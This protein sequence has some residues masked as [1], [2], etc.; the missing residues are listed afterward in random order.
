MDKDIF[1]LPVKRWDS[2]ISRLLVLFFSVWVISCGGGQEGAPIILSPAADSAKDITAFSFT[3]AT[4]TALSQD[5]TGSIA[6]TNIYAIVPDG[7]SRAGLV[8]TFSTTGQS[9]HVGGAV[10]TSGSTAND[11]TGTVTYRVTA[12]DTSTKDYLVTV[13]EAPAASGAIIADHLA[14]VAFDTIPEAA[15][16][17][18]KTRLHIAYGHTSHGSQ[19]ISGMTALA[20]LDS[21]YDWR[22]TPTA[23]A[24]H[25]DDYAMDG[26]AGYFP[27]WVNN[28][29]TYLGNPDPATGR[30]TTRPTINVVIWSWCGQVNDRTEQTMISTYLAPMTELEA[31][32]PGI[33][34]VYMTGHLNGGGTSGNVHL[35]NEQIRAYCRAYN[36]ILFD[37]A[38][39]ESFDPDGI[40]YLVRYATD[41]CNY[42]YNNSGAT[43]QTGDPA[44]P[45][46]GDRNWA[47]DWT[48]ANPGDP[49]TTLASNC[50]SCSHSQK[51]NCALKGRA[52]WWLWARLGEWDGN[53]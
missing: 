49:L 23:G 3:D 17:A 41:G 46:N 2:R 36:K 25:L 16:N 40:N 26:D 43:T 29:R 39:I 11:F 1:Q 21:L 8:A 44:T 6:G 53:P 18:A 22:E 27:A 30:G 51:L 45:I 24:L 47:V 35:R 42:D 9:V 15:I 52:V 48:A 37:F 13:N 5:V 4:N 33:Q 32:Y 34:F 31:D 19:I 20:S 10:Q 38:D 50:A 14:G 7:T 28:T 12:Q